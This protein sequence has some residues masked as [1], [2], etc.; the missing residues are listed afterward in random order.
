MLGR[1]QTICGR[2]SELSVCV[3]PTS[4]TPQLG[5]QA[6]LLSWRRGLSSLCVP[7]SGAPWSPRHGQ[8][9]L[10]TC[11]GPGEPSATLPP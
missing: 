8:A 6:S 2:R 5:A 10:G 3:E 9:V 1:V 4:C 7:L 11:S